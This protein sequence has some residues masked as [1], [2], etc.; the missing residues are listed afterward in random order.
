MTKPP[1]LYYYVDMTKRV[2]N[3]E[4]RVLNL[5]IENIGKIGRTTDRPTG[6]VL[7]IMKTAGVKVKHLDEFW[8]YIKPFPYNVSVL[9]EYK[10]WKKHR[11]S[12]N[13]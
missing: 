8:A 13:Y 5:E 1:G 2:S 6:L 11:N 10:R 12:T 9:E 7:Q 3:L 4:D